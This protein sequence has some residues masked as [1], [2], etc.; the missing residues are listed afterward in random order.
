MAR[1]TL[2]IADRFWAKVLRQSNK[3]CWPWAAQLRRN[4]YGYIRYKKEGIWGWIGAHVLSYQLHHGLVTEGLLVCHTCDNKQC[5]NPAHLFL[6]TQHDNMVDMYSKGKGNQ[7]LSL[8]DIQA[9][10]IRHQH[11][12]HREALAIEFGIHPCYVHQI[13]AE[14]STR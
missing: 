5:V 8:G 7:K 2:P 14:T 13:S 1:S 10:R 3:E 6:G 11:G 4:G 9:V 12:E